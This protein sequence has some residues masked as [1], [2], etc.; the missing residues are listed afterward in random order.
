[1]PEPPRLQNHLQLYDISGR[2]GLFFVSLPKLH[3]RL[4]RE[5]MQGHNGV[6]FR[7]CPGF[8]PEN[9][10]RFPIVRSSDNPREGETMPAN[11]KNQSCPRRVLQPLLK[12][13]ATILCLCS[14]NVWLVQAQTYS[15]MLTWHNDLARTGQNLQETVLTPANVNFKTFGKL[16]SFPVDGQIFAQPLYVY[17][18]AIP[19][20]GTYNVIYV[21]TENDS[22]Y[23]FDADGMITSALWYDSF[24]NPSKGITPIPCA[25]TGAHPCPFASVIGITGT[26]VIDS[27][28]GT[29]YLVAATKENGKYVNRLH[30]LDITTGAEK[31]GGPVQIAASVQGTGAGNN[32]GVVSFDAHHELQRPGLLLLNGVVYIGWASFG[33]VA[34]FHGWVLGYGATSLAPAGVFNST[35][36]GSDGGVW[37]SGGAPSADAAGNIY[38]LTGNGTFDINK[39][40]SDW[41]DTFLKFDASLSVTDYFTPYDQWKL[42]R[43]DLDLGSGAGMLLPPQQGKFPD[44]M[45]S[46]GK[47]GLIYVVNRSNMGRF[48]NQK[49]N[50]IQTVRGSV[51]GYWSS[52]AYWNN[53]VYFSG[54]SDFLSQ[55]SV[56]NGL[57]SNSP[58]SQAPTKFPATPSIS[59]NGSS[60]GIVWSIARPVK[61]NNEVLPAVLYACDATKISRELYNSRQAG[62][63]DLLGLGIRFSVPTIMNGKV[64]VGTYT[65]LDVLGL[66]P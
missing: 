47:E 19:G 26:P 65:E 18:V 16:F 34:P 38:L 5:P 57:L 36:N 33:D 61:P 52:P 12:L 39:G 8:W 22:V 28:S 40:G 27:S 9:S 44:E 51:N 45:V 66:L 31:F 41:G 23:A 60:N 30:A 59:A 1:L 49:N 24:I 43:N 53:S 3:V 20:K 32:H 64:Y 42:A 62:Q 46:A 17:N 11:R 63:R 48:N 50:V 14:L 6:Q 54:Q 29:L 7:C 58:V 15:G 35:P 21:V 4:D 10:N 13:A 25:D 56:T 2:R 37:Q 55:Y